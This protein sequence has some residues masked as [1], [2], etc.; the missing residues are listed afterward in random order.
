VQFR[1]EPAPSSSTV[2]A[3]LGVV[4]LFLGAAQQYATRKAERRCCRRT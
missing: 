4:M 3:D 2:F 1:E